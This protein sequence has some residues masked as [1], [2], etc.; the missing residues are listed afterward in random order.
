M[1][2]KEKSCLSEMLS[3]KTFGVWGVW[4]PKA[5][6]RRR[7]G[8]YGRE[9]IQAS[10]RAGSLPGFWLKCASEQKSFC[11]RRVYHSA[12]PARFTMGSQNAAEVKRRRA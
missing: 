8:K 5:F 9:A 12:T 4:G 7:T 10:A 11:A 2:S 3:E 1:S 6:A